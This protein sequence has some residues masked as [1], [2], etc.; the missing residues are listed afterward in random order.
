[1]SPR[2]QNANVLT[3]IWVYFIQILKLDTEYGWQILLSSCENSSATSLF[4]VVVVAGWK[5]LS[6]GLSGLE[7][8]NARH[9]CLGNYLHVAD[10]D[11]HAGGQSFHVRRPKP[12]TV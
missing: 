5:E 10:K 1:M 6:R 4:F 12:S 2:L 3:Y 11:K 8:P 9:L 7:L